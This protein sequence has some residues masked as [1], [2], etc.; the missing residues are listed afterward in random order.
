MGVKTKKTKRPLNFHKGGS[1]MGLFEWLSF[2]DLFD[3][4]LLAV[5]LALLTTEV[6]LL[7]R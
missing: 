7:R 4:L 1:R 2:R 6:K 3:S 5:E